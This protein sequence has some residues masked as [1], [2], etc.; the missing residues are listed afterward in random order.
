MSL[1][2]DFSIFDLLVNVLLFAQNAGAVTNDEADETCLELIFMGVQRLCNGWQIG[3]L[4]DKII[5][6][7]VD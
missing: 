5:Q 2:N 7:K 6:P 1:H 4:E 3:A